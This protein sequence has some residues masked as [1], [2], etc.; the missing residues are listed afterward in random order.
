MTPRTVWMV[1]AFAL[2]LLA[3]AALASRLPA[4]I[5][6]WRPL[7][8]LAFA[9][10]ASNGSHAYTLKFGYG[11]VDLDFASFGPGGKIHSFHLH[12]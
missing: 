11:C 8:S 4:E 3:N 5:H 2:G 10:V 1:A 12:Y 6:F 9:S 7:K